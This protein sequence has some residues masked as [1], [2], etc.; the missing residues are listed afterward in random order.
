MTDYRIVNYD[1]ERHIL[2]V[3]YTDAAG[4]YFREIVSVQL[5][6]ENNQVPVGD[7]LRDV[8]IA[9]YPEAYF[10]NKTAVVPV[11]NA[12][13]IL[14]LIDAPAAAGAPPFSSGWDYV[15]AER[16]RLLELS[17]WTQLPDSE[18]TEERVTAWRVYRKALREITKHYSDP[19]HVQW[20][21]P[22]LDCSNLPHSVADATYKQFAVMKY[23]G[24]ALDLK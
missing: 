12:H 3:Q 5:P 24:G 16:T 19:A 2:G 13:E 14:A 15:L 7:A 17:D 10:A 22:P 18:L 4:N 21:L 6:V 9:A 11:T 20:P 8:I 23:I 1:T